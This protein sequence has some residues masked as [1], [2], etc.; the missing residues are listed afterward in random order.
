MSYLLLNFV[1]YFVCAGINELWNT[2]YQE[3]TYFQLQAIFMV[4]LSTFVCFSMMHI[5]L[6][7]QF[8]VAVAFDDICYV[9]LFYK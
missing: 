2:F 9:I 4:P 3:C 1:I 7:M 8:Y 6:L 5:V